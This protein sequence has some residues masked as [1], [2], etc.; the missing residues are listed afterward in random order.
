[1]QKG[2][3]DLFQHKQH[4]QC[5]VSQS[6]SVAQNCLTAFWS[7]SNIR[8]RK[9][10]VALLCRGSWPLGTGCEWTVWPLLCWQHWERYMIYLWAA[11]ANPDPSALLRAGSV[12]AALCL[13]VTWDGCG[14]RVLTVNYW[15][16]EICLQTPVWFSYV[17]RME[18]R[19]A[20][21]AN[22]IVK[23]TKR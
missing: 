14:R 8:Q 5:S 15:Q 17:G 3:W 21:L 2:I 18:K 10:I 12:T 20:K 22:N 11:A 6:V 16:K 23:S 9:R 7:H 4:I 1:M 19:N 13:R